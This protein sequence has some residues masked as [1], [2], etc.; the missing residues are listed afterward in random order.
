MKRILLILLVLA[1]F[2]LAQDG[3]G[4]WLTTGSGFE[5]SDSTI[6]SN[7]D[8]VTSSDGDML[9]TGLLNLGRI[10]GV[11]AVTL[12]AASSSGTPTFDVDA[13]FYYKAAPAGHHWGD[14]NSV[15]SGVSADELQ[16]LEFNGSTP[17]WW[18]HGNGILYRI[19]QHG[20][21]SATCYLS[22]FPK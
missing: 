12:Y 18:G 2:A 9:F 10:D 17:A 13:R 1:G 6:L 5:D 16:K 19:T 4:E 21:G 15:F 14:W 11:Y 7:S 8:Y 20:T 22:H 3:Y